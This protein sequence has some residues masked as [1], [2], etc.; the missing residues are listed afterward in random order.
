MTVASG[1]LLCG[2][3]GWLV[4]DRF[5]AGTNDFAQLYAGARLAGT[6][7]LY[8]REGALRVHREAFAAELESV[9]YSRPPFYAL[10]LKPLA[11]LPYRAAFACFVSL[12]ALA[13]AW[14]F[15]A[16][17][18]RQPEILV[19]GALYPPTVVSL[20][21]GQDVALLL[22]LAAAGY[23]LL[24]RGRP[25]S[26]G[27]VWSL[28]AIKAHLFLLVPL[29][30]LLRKQWRALGGGAAGGAA[31][32]LL[33]FIAQGPGWV[34]EYAAM[35]ANAELHPG[36]DHMPNLQAV[37]LALAPGAGAWFLTGGALCVAVL[38][39]RITLRAAD[40]KAP[41][42]YALAG[43]LAISYHAYMQD[44]LMLLLAFAAALSSVPGK[45]RRVLWAIAVSPLVPL[46]LT[47]GTPWSAIP[48]LLYIALIAAAAA[49]PAEPAKTEA[50][51]P[52]RPPGPAAR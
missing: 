15:F 49:A 1:L 23:L 3:I 33:S 13:L 36:L 9:Y 45:R 11:L 38:L 39:A 51:S 24:E 35:L 16:F 18:R 7:G 8:T 10:L 43:S 27:L 20:V 19:F 41:F 37:R 31:L 14:F 52:L 34:R 32:V 12:N 30:L 28:C 21:T 5:L 42:A 26:A 47:A 2:L 40:W 25:F 6:P 48:A 17:G 44:C 29:V 4:R 50:A 46:A 22:A